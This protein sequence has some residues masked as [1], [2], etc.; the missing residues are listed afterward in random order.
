MVQVVNNAVIAYLFPGLG[1]L[2]VFNVK[3]LN[4][5]VAWSQAPCRYHQVPYTIW[6]V[7][8]LQICHLPHH[9]PLQD[10][11]PLIQLHLYCT[12]PLLQAGTL[13]KKMW[14]V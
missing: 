14:L 7:Q 9:Q 3:Q 6:N 2:V 8:A 10:M 11:L 4:P 13:N 5:A 1:G 12:D